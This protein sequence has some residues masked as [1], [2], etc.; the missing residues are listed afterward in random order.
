[1]TQRSLA[2]PGAAA[3]APITLRIT[4]TAPHRLRDVR[5]LLVHVKMPLQLIIQDWLEIEIES[6]RLLLTT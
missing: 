2:I 6:G 4:V 1:M 5:I 3:G